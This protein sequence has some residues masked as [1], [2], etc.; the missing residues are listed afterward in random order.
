LV[1]EAVLAEGS[2]C[3]SELRSALDDLASI[4]L[5]SMSDD[6]L[7]DLAGELVTAS[8]RVAAAVT[9]VV[10][11]ADRR[12]AYRRDGAVSMKAWLRGSCRMAPEQATATVSTGR[13]LEQLP[14]TAAAFAAGEISAAHARIITKGMTPGR[15]AKATDAGID[16]VR[17]TASWPIWPGQPR[18]TRQPAVSPCGSP[19]WTPTARWTTLPTPVAVSRWPLALM[20]ECTCAANWTLPVANTCTPRSPHT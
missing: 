10:R 15:L 9:T 17:P 12:E 3:V 20:D 6:A 8:N 1:S 14:Q 7:L 13:R 5:D 2:E 19:V 16:S 11:A 18:R 4:D